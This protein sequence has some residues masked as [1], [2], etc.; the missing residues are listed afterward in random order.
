MRCAAVE[1]SRG[2][3]LPSAVLDIKDVDDVV[4]FGQKGGEAKGKE[5]RRELEV[6]VVLLAL[7]FRGGGE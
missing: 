4:I 3:G 6:L 1:S 2:I 7:P 5:C